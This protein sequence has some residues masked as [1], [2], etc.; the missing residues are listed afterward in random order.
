MDLNKFIRNENALDRHSYCFPYKIILTK[1][2][3][4]FFLRQIIPNNYYIKK[5]K[6]VYFVLFLWIDVFWNYDNQKK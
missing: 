6:C 5:P 3:N 2:V 1:N 4:G